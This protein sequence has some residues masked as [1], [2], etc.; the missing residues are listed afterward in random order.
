MGFFAKKNAYPLL[1][2]FTHYGPGIFSPSC[3]YPQSRPSSL[4]PPPERGSDKSGPKLFVFRLFLA[5]T[6]ICCSSSGRQ[7]LTR[8]FHPTA[9][10]CSLELIC[11]SGSIC[12]S[13][14]EKG[15]LV[16]FFLLLLYFA[17][18]NPIPFFSM[19][20]TEG[21]FPFSSS[22]RWHV[23]SLPITWCVDG[24]RVPVP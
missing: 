4:S 6:P 21:S 11:S 3:V 14:E 22:I 5:P 24:N 9:Q 12:F 23:L 15:V 10:F 19:C 16:N 1:L 18:C 17:T 13:E 20:P 8:Y 7:N 2:I